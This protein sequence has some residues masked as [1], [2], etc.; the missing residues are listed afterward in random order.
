M[1]TSCVLP[2]LTTCQAC[3]S[4][5]GACV[6]F[7]TA[8]E[9]SDPSCLPNSDSCGKLYYCQASAVSGTDFTYKVTSDSPAPGQSILASISGYAIPASVTGTVTIQGTSA[10]VK[11]VSVDSTFL[12]VAKP[13]TFTVN[14][15]NLQGLTTLPSSVTSATY[16][17]TQATDFSNIAV[18]SGVTSLSVINQ[19]LQPK[20]PE[21]GSDNFNKLQ[22]LQRLDLSS[23]NY[24]SIDASF[25]PKLNA[26]IL[27]GNK[28]SVIPSKIFELTGLTI[29]SL[30]ENPL[31]S[32][33]ISTASFNF[34][35]NITSL[36]MP[37][38]PPSSCNGGSTLQTFKGWSICVLNDATPAPT[39]ASSTSTGLIV[40]L[41]VGGAV[42]LVVIALFFYCRHKRSHNNYMHYRGRASSNRS[43]MRPGPSNSRGSLARANNS[44]DGRSHA[45]SSA[46]AASG[47]V[48]K[49]DPSRGSEIPRSTGT[50]GASYGIFS[51]SHVQSQLG[52]LDTGNKTNQ[53]TISIGDALN[54]AIPVLHDEDMVYTRV[55][56]RGAKGVVWLAAY[57]GENCAVKKLVE[58]SST[59][60]DAA[61]GNLIVEC[62]LLFRI[63]H[64]RIISLI[65]IVPTV[66]RDGS[67]EIAM[68]MEYM[69]HGD[70]FDRLQKTKG[71]NVASFGWPGDK[72]TYALHVAEGL[73]S[74]HQRSPPIIHRDIKAR[75]VLIDSRK[76]AKICDF[77][78]SRTRSFE[79]TMT[80]NV[81][82][83]RWIAPE[84]LIN[85]DYS[86]KADIYSYGVLLSEL[87]TH[88]IPYSDANMEERQIM[89]LVAVNR[90]RPTFSRECPERIQHLARACMQADPMLRP[91][92]TRLVRTLME[93]LGSF[94]SL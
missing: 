16:K 58:G 66:T 3:P 70:L 79:E 14:G 23:S 9:C 20:L 38:T 78:E 68:V 61:L 47:V 25:P 29:L 39:P 41:S 51:N 49:S 90:L 4:A 83:A 1:S 85:E 62:N 63:Q 59:D 11:Q 8:V 84:V 56:G 15:V 81:G 60:R 10:S 5:N 93:I 31:G 19:Q 32:T 64:A 21:V 77:G 88:S 75:N 92:A 46:A 26:L 27:T 82:T 67:E 24:V 42:I 22:N 35:K 33:P 30:G 72:G 73:A 18:G 69:D 17:N 37:S 74:L 40:G 12:S 53:S 2:A 34:L 80:S 48:R 71:Q 13:T 86:E 55:L 52:G 45:N 87:D 28:L 91:D 43:G 7:N 65:G 94:V 57:A 36:T 50:G 76:G 89:Q 54:P 44:N 6:K